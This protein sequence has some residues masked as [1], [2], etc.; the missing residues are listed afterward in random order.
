MMP[1]IVAPTNGIRSR[2]ANRNANGTANGTSRRVSVRYVTPPA[3]RLI[4]KFPKT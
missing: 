2:K 1:P 3:K 4:T